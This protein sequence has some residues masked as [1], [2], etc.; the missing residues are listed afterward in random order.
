MNRDMKKNVLGNIVKLCT[1]VFKEI[2][3]QVFLHGHRVAYI[4]MRY[5]KEQ[6]KYNDYEISQMVQIAI[7]HDLGSCKL[8]ERYKDDKED[9]T[10]L[11]NHAVC[12]YIFLKNYTIYSNDMSEICLYHNIP[13]DKYPLVNSRYKEVAKLFNILNRIDEICKSKMNLD[14]EQV[15][16]DIGEDLNSDISKTFIKINKDNMIYNKIVSGEYEKELYAYL[17]TIELSREELLQYARM[18]VLCNNFR[19]RG[20]MEHSTAV[21]VNTYNLYKLL[22]MN[23]EG[24]ETITF[25]AFCHDIGKLLTPV[26]ILENPGKLTFDEMEIMKKHV[27]YTGEILRRLGLEDIAKIAELH[28]E[29][30]DGTGYPYGL[31]DEEIPMEA[32]IIA[33]ADILSALMERRSYKKEFSKEKTLSI[34]QMMADNN[35]IDRNIVKVAVENYDYLLGIS[36]GV[37]SKKR[38]KYKELLKLYNEENEKYQKLLQKNSLEF[39]EVD[40]KFYIDYN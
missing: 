24:I 7:L 29:K 38:V 19:S 11:D 4:L 3:E 8:E 25:A 2:N 28:H 39:Y 31:K 13:Y 21:E 12:G 32:K 26:E 1:D 10:E 18:I 5:L 35:K 9:T 27:E 33:V 34:L 17:D 22:G 40:N 23:T 15:L 36:K 16:Q 20:T 6:N 14:I 30:L 37:R